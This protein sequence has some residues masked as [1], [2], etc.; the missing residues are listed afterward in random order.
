MFELQMKYYEKC[1][2]DKRIN[3]RDFYNRKFL[4]YTN[5]DIDKIIDMKRN[6]YKDRDIANKL[7]RSYWGI[8][9]K[10][11]DLKSKNMI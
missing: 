5:E 7:N 10:I 4:S 6:A 3:T 9:W 2:K 1:K 11:R 8:V